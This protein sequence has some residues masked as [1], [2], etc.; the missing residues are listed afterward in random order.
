MIVDGWEDCMGQ[1]L[2]VMP[3]LNHSHGEWPLA[4]LGEQMAS[5]SHRWM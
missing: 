2:V 3:L 5:S 4:G 1:L